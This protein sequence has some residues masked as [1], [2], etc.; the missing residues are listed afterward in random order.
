MRKKA[1]CAAVVAAAA[2][3]L[4]AAPA[5]VA[6]SAQEVTIRIERGHVESV[7]ESAGV[8]FTCPG[9]Q[10]LTGRQHTGDENGRTTYY[11]STI[12][13][14]DIPVVVSPGGW[15]ERIKESN[16]IFVAPGNEA[17]VGRW[18]SGDENGY[19]RYR[20]AALTWQG[21]PVRLTFPQWTPAV[22]ESYHFSEAGPGQV[23]TGRSH[24]GDENGATQYRYSTVEVDG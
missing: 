2:T 24:Y 8:W 1:L 21:Q 14:N 9:G 4:T 19:T 5:A 6:E 17:L 16:S 15:A 7:K 10:V 13:I 23:M 12:T 22:S 11:C 3:A 18:H 20:T